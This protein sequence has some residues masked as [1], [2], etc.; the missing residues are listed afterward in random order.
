M[1]DAP[2]VILTPHVSG[3]TQQFLDDL[4]IENVRRYF[5][6]ERAAE[7]RRPGPWLLTPTMTDA[8]GS[9]PA[10]PDDGPAV[11]RIHGARR[12][13]HPRGGRSDAARPADVPGRHL[14][15]DHFR[16]RH[17]DR[18]GVRLG[19][20][21]V[22]SAPSWL[23]SRCRCFSASASRCSSLPSCAPWPAAASGGRRLV[24]A[25]LVVLGWNAVLQPPT[26]G[27]FV[28]VALVAIGAGLLSRRRG[29]AAAPLD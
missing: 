18:V 7:H 9:E 1:W 24:G 29:T 19:R 4:V 23:L 2:N 21:A 17:D 28:P 10:A 22:S 3:A 13:V 27:P 16:V 26:G 5:A 15:T 25:V 8:A 20:H 12:R 11:A 6:G 14:A